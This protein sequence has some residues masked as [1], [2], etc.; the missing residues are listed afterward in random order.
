MYNKNQ[1]PRTERWEKKYI[2]ENGTDILNEITMNERT[3]VEIY[4]KNYKTKPPPKYA[5]NW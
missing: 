2:S 4:G 3:Q 1:N 5:T